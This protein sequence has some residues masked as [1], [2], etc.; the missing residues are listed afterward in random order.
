MKF[1]PKH[2]HQ[3][4]AGEMCNL[5]NYSCLPTQKCKHDNN[6]FAYTFE[7]P[8]MKKNIFPSICFTISSIHSPLSPLENTLKKSHR[9]EEAKHLSRCSFSAFST[10]VYSKERFSLFG[11]SH[12]E[13]RVKSMNRIQREEK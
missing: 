6:S 3:S 10:S 8:S 1:I 2:H 12:I 9:K 4:L 7:L 11:N 13:P 5:L